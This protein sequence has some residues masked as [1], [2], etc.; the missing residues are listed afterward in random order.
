[1]RLSLSS[2]PTNSYHFGAKHVNVCTECVFYDIYG[3]TRRSTVPVGYPG[4]ITPL[5]YPPRSHSRVRWCESPPLCGNVFLLFSSWNKISAFTTVSGPATVLTDCRVVVRKIVRV[6]KRIER[7][8]VHLVSRDDHFAEVDHE[9]DRGDLRHLATKWSDLVDVFARHYLWNTADHVRAP[10]EL[11]YL[12]QAAR[13]R[14]Y[15]NPMHTFLVTDR[16]LRPAN[17]FPDPGECS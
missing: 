10:R 14:D 4:A 1:M 3:P 12:T 16:C 2:P 6:P 5:V 15:S 17:G 7:K 11:H 13:S 8:L 9:V